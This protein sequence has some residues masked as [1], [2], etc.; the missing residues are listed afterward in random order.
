MTELGADVMARFVGPENV[1]RGREYLEALDPE[2]CLGDD[3]ADPRG[4]PNQRHGR[5]R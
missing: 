5:T 2:E 3:E 4:V 1:D